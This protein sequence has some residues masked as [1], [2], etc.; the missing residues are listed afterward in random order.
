MQFNSF[1]TRAAALAGVAAIAAL[2]VMPAFADEPPPAKAP[3]K[4][5]KA[6]MMATKAPVK[7]KKAMA[8]AT[9]APIMATKAPPHVTPIFTW[10][11][12]YVGGYIGGAA[13]TNVTTPD[14]ICQNSVAPCVAGA[15]YAGT[16]PVSYG[17]KSSVIGGGKAGYNLQFGQS[18]VGVEGEY[19]YIHL[20]GSAPFTTF[21]TGAPAAPPGAIANETAFSTLGNWY[22]TITGRVGLTGDY[23]SPEWSQLLF[24]AKGGAALTR[25]STGVST[26]NTAPFAFALSN[27]SATKNVW[28]M[29]L[30]GGVEWAIDANWSVQA[31]YEYLG[32][33]QSVQACGNETTAAGAPLGAIDCTS[34]GMP[35]VHTGKIGINYRFGS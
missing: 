12:F 34:T 19:G 15:G 10:T 22:A 3:V 24:Y 28:G 27:E 13:A 30:G 17:L 8:M 9:K 1:V 7:A 4:A 2:A 25:F 18:V 6:P 33:R 16:N 11:G 21:T 23:F 29:A 32:F 14:P 26:F 31:E 35:Q 5:K 20:P